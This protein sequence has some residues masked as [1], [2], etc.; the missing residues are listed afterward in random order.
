MK[1]KQTI[2][3][4]ATLVIFSM[5]GAGQ[6]Q[7][8][9]RHGA[10]RSGGHAGAD[11]RENVRDRH[12]NVKDRAEDIRDKKEDVRDAKHDGGIRDKKEDRR[13]RAEDIRDKKEDVKD[14]AEN[15]RDRHHG[16]DA[17]RERILEKNDANGDGKLSDG[18]KEA[19]R[20]AYQQRV[21]NF[22]EHRQEIRS[23]FDVDGNGKL[24]G[25]ELKKALEFYR[26]HRADY[27][28]VADA[29]NIE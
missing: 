13:D 28:N 27:R 12:E 1:A 6:L 9:G 16:A 10:V 2:P 7:A 24:T 3:W 4:M 11:R 17:A 19:A 8:E 25:D 26:E 5:A 21:S 29:P 14:R 23:R 18:E 15:V 22:M 20:K